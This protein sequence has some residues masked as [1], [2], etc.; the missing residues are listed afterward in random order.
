MGHHSPTAGSINM[1][2]GVHYPKDLDVHINTTDWNIKVLNSSEDTHSSRYPNRVVDAPKITMR[3]RHL[4][5]YEFHAQ[6]E[7]IINNNIWDFIKI[8]TSKLFL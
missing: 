6:E 5:K 3:C 2:I 7:F 1:P 8:H 4:M